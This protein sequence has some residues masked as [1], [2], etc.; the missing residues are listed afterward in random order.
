M[1]SEHS[2]V[3]LGSQPRA[4]PPLAQPPLFS[5]STPGPPSVSGVQ[6]ILSPTSRAITP[7]VTLS[8]FAPLT[9]SSGT[10]QPTA[11]SQ[12][13]QPTR[14]DALPNTALPVQWHSTT[15]TGQPPPIWASK[16]GPTSIWNPQSSPNALN[17]TKITPS[18]LALGHTMQPTSSTVQQPHSSA[19]TNTYSGFSIPPPPTMSTMP[20]Q[21]RSNGNSVI[22]S[23]ASKQTTTISGQKQGL[24]GYDSLL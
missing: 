20:L 9:P 10:M 24:D 18:S 5:W 3:L 2:N 19:A 8:S 6:P 21:P 7:D 4:Q 22:A 16:Y 14:P 12:P 13:L 11:F 17:G 15:G 23:T 1:P